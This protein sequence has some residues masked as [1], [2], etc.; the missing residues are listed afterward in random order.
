MTDP[1]LARLATLAAM[2][3]DAELARIAEPSRRL[4]ALDRHLA[5]L[6]Q[7]SALPADMADAL[8]AQRHAVWA[9]AR[10]S[11]LLTERAKVE[12]ERQ[13]RLHSARVALARADLIAR[14]ADKRR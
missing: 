9:D 3:R 2:I 8:A 13:A 12:D 14:L 4:A 5:A 1:R 10:R 6:D 7:P 11:V